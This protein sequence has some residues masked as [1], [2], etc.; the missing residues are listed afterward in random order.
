MTNIYIKENSYIIDSIGLK[1]E[2]LIT[3][4]NKNKKLSR[5]LSL[6]K[7]I[8]TLLMQKKLR[9]ITSIIYDNNLNIAHKVNLL[10]A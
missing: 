9:Q 10:Y 8:F 7:V 1:K 3:I 2:K 4:L 5:V 6:P